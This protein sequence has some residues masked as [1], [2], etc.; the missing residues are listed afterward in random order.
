MSQE[1]KETVQQL[2]RN[3]QSLAPEARDEFLTEACAGDESLRT[4]VEALVTTNLFA[5]TVAEG[6]N[7]ERE[8][9][10]GGMGAV[11]LAERADRQFQQRVALKLIKKGMEFGEVFRRFRYERQI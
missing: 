1:R 4:E 6:R 5:T 11:Y 9:G 10:H 7:M 3:A 2:A 8:I